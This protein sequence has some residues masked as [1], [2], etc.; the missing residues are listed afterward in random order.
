MTYHP[1]PQ[2]ARLNEAIAAGFAALKGNAHMPN[3]GISDLQTAV[4]KLQAFAA[5]VAT[6][7]STLQAASSA[8]AND[9]DADI[10]TLAQQVNASIATIQAAMP[11]AA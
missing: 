5:T 10:E 3:Q 2:L 1:L 7:L 9:P 8:V 6:E 11:V 4:T